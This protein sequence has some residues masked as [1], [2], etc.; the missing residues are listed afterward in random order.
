MEYKVP[1][2]KYLHQVVRSCFDIIPDS[3]E[4][5]GKRGTL[6]MA[7]ISGDY[8]WELYDWEFLC[9]RCH[10]NK[11]GRMK[12]LKKG[13]W[14]SKTFCHCGKPSVVRNGVCM[15]HYNKSRRQKRSLPV[16]INNI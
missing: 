12:N 5:C 3:C 4:K 1:N 10:M 16:K 6:D 2:Y 15:Y 7:N 11:D 13:R 14:S 9:R 8:V